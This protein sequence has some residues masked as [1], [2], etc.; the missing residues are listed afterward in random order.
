MRLNFS[1]RSTMRTRRRLND[2]AACLRGSPPP[3]GDWLGVI[4][5]AN[6]SLV[7]PALAA[8]LRSE[9]CPQDVNEYLTLIVERNAARNKRLL[10]QLDEVTACLNAA[11]I[12]PTLIK[13][14]AWLRTALPM[15]LG[16]R[17]L[18]DLDI[19]VSVADIDGAMRALD[20]VGFHIDSA[21]D[22]AQHHFKADMFRSSDAAMIDLHVRPPGPSRL[23]PPARLAAHT[24]TSGPPERVAGLPDATLQAFHILVHDLFHDGDFWVGR[25]DLRHLLDMDALSREPD[26]SWDLISDW[27]ST[28]LDR[29]ALATQCLALSELLGTPVP[30]SLLAIRGARLQHRRRMLQLD[31]PHLRPVFSAATILA[32]GGSTACSETTGRRETSAPQARRPLRDRINRLRRIWSS[33]ETGKL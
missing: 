20:R 25:I 24:R 21:V 19:I 33:A 10:D 29:T 27:M 1:G 26:F 7:T 28:P 31:W 30:E 2:L 5:D 23:H 13:G 4:E 12:V 8:R 15:R 17:M 14:T 9:L 6:R 22:D 11:G 18:T 16:D 3:G 32:H